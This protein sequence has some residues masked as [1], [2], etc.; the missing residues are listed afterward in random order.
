MLGV[1]GIAFSERETYSF[2][3]LQQVLLVG[4]F[5]FK[6]RFTGKDPIDDDD[7]DDEER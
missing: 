1:L 3:S 6:S 2:L 4:Y 5:I 7:K